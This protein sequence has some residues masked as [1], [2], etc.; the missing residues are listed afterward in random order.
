MHE[1][2]FLLSAVVLLD[3]HL[4]WDATSRTQKKFFQLNIVEKLVWKQG[5]DTN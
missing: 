2:K 3:F 5:L 1:R 4:P